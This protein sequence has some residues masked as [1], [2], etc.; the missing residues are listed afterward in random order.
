M[1]QTEFWKLPQLPEVEFFKA[2]FTDFTYA[3]HFH[4]DY[5]IGVVESGIHAFYYRGE[6]HAI[7]PNYVVT[8]QP[9][10]MHNGHPGSDAAWR[11]RM[12]YLRPALLCQIAGELGYRSSA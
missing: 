2:Q 8:C 9:G 1:N 3:P 10:E 6:N 11:Y 5:A 4:E 12:M 7:A